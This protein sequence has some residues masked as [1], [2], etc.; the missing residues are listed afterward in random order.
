MQ[1]RIVLDHVQPPRVASNC[2]NGGKRCTP[3]HGQRKL[4]IPA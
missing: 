1:I 2:E 4:Q 3:G